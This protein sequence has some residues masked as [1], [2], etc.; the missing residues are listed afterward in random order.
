MQLV[1][2]FF[3]LTADIPSMKNVW[4]LVEWARGVCWSKRMKDW[5]G[6]PGSTFWEPLLTLLCYPRPNYR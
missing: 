4:H 6:G 5:L 2:F 1:N 3:M